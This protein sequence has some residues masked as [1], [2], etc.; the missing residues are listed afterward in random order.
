MAYMDTKSVV[1]LSFDDSTY[2]IIPAMK[3]RATKDYN[4]KPVFLVGNAGFESTNWIRGLS[5]PAVAVQCIP[6]RYWFTTPNL[7]KMLGPAG[8]TGGRSATTGFLPSISSGT[9]HGIAFMA[10]NPSASDSL[11]ADF[12]KAFLSGMTLTGG[13][14]GTP[15]MCSMG[16]LPAGSLLASSLPSRDNGA[17]TLGGA[18]IFMSDGASFNSTLNDL[19][20]FSLTFSNGMAPD[21]AL[22]GSTATDSSAAIFPVGYLSGPIGVGATLIQRAGASIQP[23][24]NDPAL[25]SSFEIWLSSEEVSNTPT[26]TVVKILIS[27]LDPSRYSETQIG[28]SL[29]SRTYIGQAQFVT[30][31]LVSKLRFA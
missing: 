7:N 13:G 15:I 21:T 23:D 6:H 25:L 8:A 14:Q 9:A 1:A 29:I 24:L 11:V 2:K 3:I 16:L 27:G 10:G 18:G 30:G 20:G 5:Q 28:T 19:E 12:S 17:M 4:V 22:Q 31:S 26:P